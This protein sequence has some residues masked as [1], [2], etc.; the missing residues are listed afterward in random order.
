MVQEALMHRKHIIV[1]E[2]SYDVTLS[3][4]DRQVRDSLASLNTEL[5]EAGHINSTNVIYS[6]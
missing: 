3:F 5:I 1:L 2:L 4:F 6:E